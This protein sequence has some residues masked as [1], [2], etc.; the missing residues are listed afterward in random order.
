M[1]YSCL[2]LVL[3]R[4]PVCLISLRIVISLFFEAVDGILDFILSIKCRGSKHP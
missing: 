1:G 4:P 2:Y 3:L